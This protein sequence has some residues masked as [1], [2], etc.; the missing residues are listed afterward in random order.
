MLN[1]LVLIGVALVLAACST[2]QVAD[3]PA[4]VYSSSASGDGGSL[5]TGRIGSLADLVGGD[6]VVYF[7]FNSTALSD[8]AQ[9]IVLA[10][11]EGLQ[12]H[13]DVIVVVEGHC[14]ERGSREYNLA[15][16]EQRANAIRD[17]LIS[18]GVTGDRIA[19]ISYGKERPVVSGHNVDA[20]SLNRRGVLT[21]G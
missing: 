6:T 11:A 15:L 20:W 4:V 18:L 1:R 21:L 2:P 9:T 5:D 7:A 10:W 16:G 3:D 19:T 12:A 8:D 14:D 13:D 17:L